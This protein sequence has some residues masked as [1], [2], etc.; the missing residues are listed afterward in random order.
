MALEQAPAQVEPDQTRVQGHGDLLDATS[1]RIEH[2]RARRAERAR[3]G[4][5][6]ACRAVHLEAQRLADARQAARGELAADVA[7]DAVPARRAHDAIDVAVGVDVPE[8]EGRRLV[9]ARR[10]DRGGI[11]EVAYPV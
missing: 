2:A 4:P 1:I 9:L 5:A 10:E 8:G 11:A 6:A 7:Q 3:Q